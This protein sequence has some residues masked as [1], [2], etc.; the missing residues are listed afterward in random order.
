MNKNKIIVISISLIILLVITIIVFNNLIANKKSVYTSKY[1]VKD[2]NNDALLKAKEDVYNLCTAVAKRN[3]SMCN[4]MIDNENK[5]TCQMVQKMIAARESNSRYVCDTDESINNSFFGKLICTNMFNKNTSVCEDFS[6]NESM[7]KECIIFLNLTFDEI[8]QNDVP[9]KLNRD[10][11]FYTEFYTRKALIRNNVSLCEGLPKDIL[12][13]TT[14]S[15][16]FNNFFV[17]RSLFGID[18]CQEIMN[19]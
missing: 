16:I 11:E 8:T 1:Y 10:P 4:N 9:P 14:T 19:K 6:T 5:H 15:R 2:L 12:E 13:F 7:K 3:E 18:Q 17:C